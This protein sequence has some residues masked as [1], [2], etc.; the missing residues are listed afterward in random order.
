M[1]LNERYVFIVITAYHTQRFNSYRYIFIYIFICT[2]TQ[3]DMRYTLLI[4][5]NINVMR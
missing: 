5:Y 2:H 1:K 3:C 4:I